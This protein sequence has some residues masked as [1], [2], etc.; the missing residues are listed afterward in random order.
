MLFLREDWKLFRNIETLSQKAGVPQE[1]IPSLVVKELVDNALDVGSTCEL[2]LLPGINGFYVHDS[3]EGMDPGELQELFSVSRPLLSSKLLRLPTRGALGNGLRVVSGAV[4]ASGGHIQVDTRGKKYHLNFD[5]D[6]NTNVAEIGDC[7]GQG[8]RVSVIFGA[9]LPVRDS[10]LSWGRLSIAFARGTEF[11]CKTSPF[12]YT[13]EAFYELADSYYG[14]VETLAA[15]FDGITRGKAKELAALFPDRTSAQLSFDETE[16]ILHQLR[17]NSQEIKQSRLGQIGELPDF[18]DYAAAAGYHHMKSLR[19]Q[20]SAAIPYFVE[21]WVS[22]AEKST[23]TFLVNKTRITGDVRIYDDRGKISLFGCGLAHSI[24]SKSADIIINV[25]TPYMPITSDGK[26]PDL[27]P[28]ANEIA[29]AIRRAAAK[30]RRTVS[31]NKNTGRRNEKEIMLHYL[32]EAVSKAS[33]Q[34]VYKFSQRQLYYAIRP[35]VITQLDK[36]PDYNYFCRVITEYEAENGNIPAMY[37]DPRGVLYHP[38]LKE[39][40]PIGTISVENYERPEWTFNK[41]LYSE[42]EGFFTILKDAK[43]PERFDCALLTS[44]GYA[45]RAVKDLFDFLGDTDE[46]ILFFCIHDAD[47]AG[48]KIY[49]TLQ[50]GTMARPG[51][52]VRVVNLG[53]EPEEALAMGLE[54][55]TAERAIGRRP[56]AGYLADE[57]REWL[58]DNRVEL[59][60]MTSPQFLEWLE[61]KISAHGVRKVVPDNQVMRKTL[62][63][64][65]IALTAQQVQEQIL[66][67]AGYDHRVRQ[68][69]QAITPMIEQEASSLTRVVASQLDLNEEAHWSQPVRDVAKKIV[70]KL[71]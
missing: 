20:H 65:V 54:V 53:L 67:E 60:A 48:T 51:R 21:A 62:Q 37:R 27:E 30:A 8:T 1:S 29:D 7:S 43:F 36:Q 2:D 69:I 25:Q 10:D 42:K 40:I 41:I 45:S 59:N 4:L 46:E 6:G 35:Y 50:E 32:P 71:T 28:M 58:Q 26:E 3:G 56:V 5:Q 23:L 57:W 18:R 13:S 38:H 34:G 70:E 9:N 66:R 24:K 16:N 55:E 49:E 19:G 39:E 47:A 12:W 22:L 44:K 52:R 14:P 17:A 64:E 68:A 33:G 63:E 11:K 61:V 15:S 31:H